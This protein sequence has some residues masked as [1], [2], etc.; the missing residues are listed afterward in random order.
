MTKKPERE[1]SRLGSML[2]F[3]IYS[4]AHAF[5]R[6]YKPL[7]DALGLTYP[8][9]LVMVALWEQDDISVKEIGELLHLDSGTLTPL[10]KR[11]E[12]MGFVRRN[13]DTADERS[14]RISLTSAGAAPR[15]KE[16]TV[17]VGIV[18]ACGQTAEHL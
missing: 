7:L 18:G 6:A 16:K 13:R 10:L 3:T 12:A 4:T 17:S 1:P 8:Q 14:V 15:Q 9:Y 5:N 2:C 11:L